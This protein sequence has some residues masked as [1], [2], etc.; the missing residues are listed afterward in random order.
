[1][2]IN[3]QT[4]TLKIMNKLTKTNTPKNC[5]EMYLEYVN[6]WLT[7]ESMAEYHNLEI[8]D[9]ERIIE[10]GKKEHNT[11]S[12]TPLKIMKNQLINELKIGNSIKFENLNEF[13]YENA[14]TIFDIELD[15]KNDRNGNRFIVWVNS[16]IK[17]VYKDANSFA[18][19]VTELVE[20]NK[21][22]RI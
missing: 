1:M 10:I 12:N 4:L 14:N 5:T 18:N 2:I 9:L 21:L 19:K 7:L 3:K 17:H 15:Y 11:E 16:V 6:D 13:D 8:K 20:N 22:T